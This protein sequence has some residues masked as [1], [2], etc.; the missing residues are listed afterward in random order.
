MKCERRSHYIIHHKSFEIYFSMRWM[1]FTTLTM[2]K[3]C[4]WKQCGVSLWWKT[5][6]S[7]SIRKYYHRRNRTKKMHFKD[8]LNWFWLF[9]FAAC[10]RREMSERMNS[11]VSERQICI[12]WNSVR[13]IKLEEKRHYFSFS[14]HSI[15]PVEM[16][17]R[18]YRRSSVEI[19]VHFTTWYSAIITCI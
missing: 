16:L 19:L 15:D 12:Y 1:W 7:W 5:S 11:T 9:S 17:V 4:M 3:K 6:G 8:K 18:R 13:N 2:N 14:S 10:Q